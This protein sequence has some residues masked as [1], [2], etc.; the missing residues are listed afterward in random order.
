MSR[1]SR[2]EAFGFAGKDDGDVTLQALQ[3]LWSLLGCDQA[4]RGLDYFIFDTGLVCGAE[5][6]FRWINLL[7]DSTD[8]EATIAGIELF[9]RRRQKSDPL[10][11]QHG[12]EWSNRCNRAKKRALKMLYEQGL[13]APYLK[14]EKE[15]L[16]DEAS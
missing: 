8:A 3:H 4:P 9:R 5:N 14:Q 15:L 2:S 1:E 6:V 7:S 10:W 11:H 16:R 12:T 13:K